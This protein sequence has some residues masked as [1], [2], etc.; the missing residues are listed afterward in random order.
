MCV[1]QYSRQDHKTVNSKNS[2]MTHWHVNMREAA[3]G[4]SLC[5]SKVRIPCLGSVYAV[6]QGHQQRRLSRCCASDPALRHL[7]L[8]DAR[9]KNR[10]WLHKQET[11]SFSC[12]LPWTLLLRFRWINNEFLSLIPVSLLQFLSTLEESRA[13]CVFVLS[14]TCQQ[15]CFHYHESY[16]FENEDRC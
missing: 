14:S 5:N 7:H 3:R 15:V 2:K 13:N 10:V 12:L 6:L 1:T 4:V 11:E 16:S 9:L 8:W